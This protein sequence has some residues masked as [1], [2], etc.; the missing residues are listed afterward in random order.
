MSISKVWADLDILSSAIKLDTG[1]MACPLPLL[2]TKQ[3]LHALHSGQVLWL[4]STQPSLL[5]DI[6]ALVHQTHDQL[7]AQKQ[8][9]V[10]FHFLIR[11]A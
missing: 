6:K 2:K 7:L 5:L 4:I 9:G 8:E 3:A 11:K 10:S 1:N